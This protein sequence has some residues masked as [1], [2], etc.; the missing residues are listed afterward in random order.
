MT[1][2]AKQ[3]YAQRK[4]YSLENRVRHIRLR[5]AGC[6]RSTCRTARGMRVGGFDGIQRKLRERGGE[7]NPHPMTGLPRP[8]IHLTAED[9]E[10][11]RELASTIS[12]AGFQSFSQSINPY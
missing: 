7:P 5:R 8:C 2:K 12:A 6:R 1:A 9:I 3:N 11:Q 10:R 4:F